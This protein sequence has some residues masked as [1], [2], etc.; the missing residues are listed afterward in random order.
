MDVT[1]IS[2]QTHEWDLLAQ[3]ALCGQNGVTDLDLALFTQYVINLLQRYVPCPWGLFVVVEN[4]TIHTQASWGLSREEEGQLLQRNG[5]KLYADEQYYPLR[6]GAEELGYLLL[7]TNNEVQP[8]F[9]NALAAQLSLL[10]F[11]QR[12]TA[13][14]RQAATPDVDTPTRQQVDLE[15]LLVMSQQLSAKVSLNE[16]FDTLLMVA[17]NLVDCTGIQIC[18]YVPSAQAL[19]VV[20]QVGV[21]TTEKWAGQQLSAWL[22]QERHMLRLNDVHH[23]HVPNVD[24]QTVFAE[25]HAIRSYLGFPLRV[26]DELAGTLELVSDQVGAFSAE[27]EQL[28][29]IA[30]LLAAR[31]IIGVRQAEQAEEHLHLRIQQLRAL[32]RVSSQL[33][34]TLY[35]EEI[36]AF[37]LE[38]ALRA[39]YA[40]HGLIVLRERDVAQDSSW[41]QS[42]LI[43]TTAG[44]SEAD[45]EHL[46]HHQIDERFTTTLAAL[47]RGEPEVS[48]SLSDAERD[49]TRC[50]DAQAA[51]AVPIFYEGG[52]FGAIL[53]L[54]PQ[55]SGFDQEVTEF[56]RALANQTALAIGN[57]QRY[58]EQVNQLRLLQQRESILRSVLEI[59]QALRADRSLGDLLEQIG[60]S[61]IETA[62]FRSVIFW[63]IDR[64]NPDA[65]H[66]VAGAGIPLNEL[67]RIA[68]SMFP[69]EFAQRCLDPRFRIG[70]SFFVPT[71]VAPLVERNLDVRPFSY[72]GYDLSQ[73]PDGPAE[74]IA[75]IVDLDTYDVEVI[76]RTEWQYKDRLFVPLNSTDDRLLGIMEVCDPINRQRPTVRTTELLEILADQAA[77]AI[78]NNYL[79]REAR[80]TA[81]QMTIL[82]RVGVA[83]ASTVDLDVLLKQVYQQ[84]VSYKGM[85]SY[86][87]VASYLPQR[88]QM[89]FE[90]FMEQGKVAQRLHKK[91]VSKTGMTGWIIDHGQPLLIRDLEVERDILPVA[92][93]FRGNQQIRS[94]LGVP[95]RIQNRILGVLSVQEVVPNA[96]SE[97]DTQ[98]FTVLAN[99]LAIAIENL[100]LFQ[101]RERRL[102]ELDVINRIGNITSSTLDLHQMLRQIYDCLAA[103]L[104]I[105]IFNAYIY[106]TLSNEISL[107]L[108]GYQGTCTIHTRP[109][110]PLRGSLVERIIQTRQP[111]VF[112]NLVAE[113]LDA[114]FNPYP[115]VGSI[116]IQP[117]SWLG[118]PLLVGDGEVVGAIVIQNYVPDLYGERELVFLNTVANQIALGVHNARLFA[119]S[120]QQVLKLK[121]LNRVSSAAAATLEPE[122]IHTA[123]I[124]AM[125]QVTGAD[126]ARMVIYDRQRGVA[127]I[128][129][130]YLKTDVPNTVTIPLIDN[131]VIDW[132]DQHLC[133]LMVSDAQ[134]DP[135]FVRSHAVFQQLNIVSIALI[136]LIIGGE[137][138][139]CVGL[140]FV[141]QQTHLSPQNLELCQ[142]IAN[143]AVTAIEN[144]RLFAEAQA[145]ARALQ[146]KVGELSTL[147]EAARIL[148]SLLQPNEV[149]KNLMDLVRRQLNVTTAALWSIGSDN[150]LTPTAMDGIPAEIG[151]VM[152]VPIGQ[153]ITGHVAATNM[154]LVIN[155]V[156]AYG[157]SL[158]PE[159]NRSHGLTSYMGV[160][161]VSREQTI[162]VLSVMTTAYRAFSADEVRL[163]SGLADQAAIALENAR[164]FQERERRISELMSINKISAAVTARLNLD[165][166]LLELHRGIS[167]II[168]VSTSFIGLYD[169]QTHM[170]SYPIAYDRGHQVCLVPTPLSQELSDWVLRNHQPLLL[171]SVEQVRN[172]GLDLERERIGAESTEQS[173]LIVP[174]MSSDRVLGVINIQ[175]YESHAFDEDDLRFVHTIANQAA[176]AINNARLFQERGRRIEELATF[177][178]IGQ[179]LSATVSFEELTTL[180]YR[181]TSRL[182]DTTNFY[183]ALLDEAHNEIF[184]P[185][186][187]EEGQSR[188]MPSSRD[189]N[190]LTRYVIRTRET[191]LLQEPGMHAQLAALNID[192]FPTERIPRAWL[193]VP[194]I[195]ADKVVGVI[196]IQDYEHEHAYGPDEIRLLATIA[197]WA[198]I[199]LENARLIAESRQNVRELTALYDVSVKLSG[200]LDM[201][202]IQHMVAQA[203]LDL[204]DV[205][206][207]AVTG[208]DAMGQLLKPVMADRNVTHTSWYQTIINEHLMMQ[209]LQ[210]EQPLAITDLY[211]TD[212]HLFEGQW[213]IRG[214]LGVTLGTRDTRIGAIWVGTRLPHEWTEHQVSL[215]LILANQAGQALKSAQ[216]FDQVRNLAADLERRVIERTAALEAANNQII[217]EKER[218][219]V[220]HEITLALTETLDLTEIIN[221]ALEMSSNY[222]G[223][224]RGSIMLREQQTGDLVCRAVLQDQGVVRSAS[225]LISFTEGGGL[226]AWVIRNQEPAHIDDVRLDKRWIV[227]QGRADD[228]RSVVAVP[229]MTRDATLGVLILTS[230]VIGYFTE[231]QVRLLATIA[232][233]VAIAI[234]NATLYGYITEMASR[235]ADL[236][237]QQREE[238]SK[239]RAILQSVSEGVIVL[240]E[241]QRIALFNPAAESVLGIPARDVLDRPM[242]LLASQG[243]SEVKRKR[244][245]MI[246]QGLQEGLSRAAEQK[247]GIYSMSLEL[248]DPQQTIAVNFAPVVGPDERRYGDVAVLHD[249]TREIEADRAKREFISKVSHELRTPLTAIKGHVDLLLLGTLGPLNESQKSCLTVAKNNSNRLRDLIED[250]LDI[251]RIESG[252]IKL[253]FRQ[254][255]IRMVIN[256]VVQSLKLEAERQQMT[257][258]IEVEDQ[259]PP[260][261]A[262]QKRLTQVVFNLF[263]NA[264]KYTYAQGRIW[265]RAFL[266]PANMVQVEVEDTGV[267]M[268]PEQCAKLFRPFYRADNPLR[269]AVGGTGLGLSIAKS[270][271][272][273]HGGQMWVTSELGK[274]STFSFIIP[275]EQPEIPTPVDGDDV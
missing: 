149:L 44:Y 196:S 60:Y 156:E 181:Q 56:V 202:T 59:G 32:Q 42:Y 85:P 236:L 201:E 68:R 127:P 140:D 109:H 161:V 212:P 10:L 54:A 113:Q 64:E 193:G 260:V 211:E 83:A 125:V 228:V 183:M 62:N 178:E 51:L 57:A 162:G 154:P 224:S 30:G 230:P 17:Q 24:L 271:V 133:P 268:S 174:I 148:S 88:E 108:E 87:F 177:N 267:G 247:H 249:V 237:E 118:V 151:Y 203:A 18:T 231:G 143:Q 206:V 195:V 233:E 112:A 2:H 214:V 242:V 216:L 145:N 67:D 131:P 157:N 96:F 84:I 209:L 138:I 75:T 90:L 187:Y 47:Q 12:H 229:L 53:L 186:F 7:A 19:S 124:D 171:H 169:E 238:A 275:L 77:L 66:A 158:Y 4:G 128:V 142:T 6:V 215:L 100:G 147:L 110:P 101:E 270:L 146:V 16:I 266:N 91:V 265:I 176:V 185:L 5:S 14:R 28:L 120:E 256:D 52:V 220:V 213:D 252:K 241:D 93:V 136:P 27:D 99:Q 226:A 20:C 253:E 48:V 33:T 63:L 22:L 273:Q 239:S 46:L 92:P 26:D 204:L 86:F 111:L 152:R 70:R 78:E 221:R 165:D 123:M 258:E 117:A 208:Y 95:L 72:A 13:K 192:P 248:S 223:V 82:F 269:D 129:A 234:N 121:L 155:D 132:L 71:E 65:L 104:P 105:D 50:G 259:L 23:D 106:H 240:D 227:E 122:Q 49:A 98:F 40:S 191:L 150:M 199:A 35:Q 179:A 15:P 116:E 160:P 205:E 207:S 167:E 244:A 94:W 197:S 31:A 36:L 141:Q 194:M 115:L 243:Q 43:V 166:L 89:R 135:L 184:F 79:L 255:D 232:N 264:V 200:T 222:L 272:E 55:S 38:Q 159:F 41:L 163:L 1:T 210:T 107:F 21:Y 153:G 134:K 9:Y 61:V 74:D 250:I 198:A 173:F 188:Q 25:M 34:M 189:D 180:I 102:A 218:L 246:Y 235:L 257:V 126:Q 164:L 45:A 3:L 175:S 144:A 262:D 190:S 29:W 254:V 69:M 225:Q 170:L 251:S 11:T 119:E 217:Q 76:T 172:M 97:R 73:V 37:V 219:E 8:T 139:G 263:S 39:T 58:T 81:E 114:G 168:D 182:L 80:S 274:G 245:R 103:F 130:E 261:I 137:V